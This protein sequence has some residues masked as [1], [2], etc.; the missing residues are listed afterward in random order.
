MSDYSE[1][2]NEYYDYKAIHYPWVKTLGK[3]LLKVFQ[4]TYYKLEQGSAAAFVL[5]LSCF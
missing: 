4:N 5:S 1:D 2:L 3:C